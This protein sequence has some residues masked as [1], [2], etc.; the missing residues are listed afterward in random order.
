M[1]FSIF[2]TFLLTLTVTSYLFLFSLTHYYKL[3]CDC[4]LLFGFSSANDYFKFLTKYLATFTGED[5]LNEAKEEA[6]HAIVEFIK[7]P[8]L[9]KVF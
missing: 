5:D 7:A 2:F 3:I 6:A 8:N 9:F 1:S 4:Q